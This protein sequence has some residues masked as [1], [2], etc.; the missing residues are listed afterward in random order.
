M[1]EKERNFYDKAKSAIYA[2]IFREPAA[3]AQT[4]YDRQ[5]RKK[6]VDSKSFRLYQEAAETGQ[7]F[8]CFSVGRC[9][10]EGRVV[11]KDLEKAYEWYQKGAT[12]G[13]VNA[14]VALGRMFDQGIYVDRDPKLSQMWL[15][16]AANKGHPLGMIGLG[17]Y[18]A[19]GEGGEKDQ[20]RALELFEQAHELNKGIA[21]YVLGEAI[22]DGIGCEKNYEKAFELF[23]EA[24]ANNYP[25][26]TFNVGMMLEMGLGC[27]KDEKKG[28]EF[29]QK[30]A[31]QGVSD[32]MYRLAFDYRD[33]SKFVEKD[34]KKS[35][36]LFLKAAEAGNIKACQEVGLMYENGGG[37]EKDE[38]KAFEYYEKAAK[39]GLH[40]AIVCLAV[41]YRSGIGCERDPQKARE[42]LEIGV[43]L[44]NTR[45]YHL[46]ALA[47]FEEDPND[48]RAV[49]LEMVAAKG[50]FN[51]S[52]MTLAY[53]FLQK[54]DVA[55]DKEKAKYYYR[56]AA[57]QGDSTAAFELAELLSSEENNQDQSVQKEIDALYH[58]SAENRHP[59]AAF[60]LAKQL[61]GT[62]DEEKY[63]KYMS[64]AASG[65]IAEAA[66]EMAERHFWGNKMAI[67]IPV[68]SA[69]F[70]FAADELCSDE[71]AAKGAITRI[72][73][74]NENKFWAIGNYRM[75]RLEKNLLSTK[76]TN[77]D[78]KHADESKECLQ[79]LEE[80]A[81]GGMELA[82]IF[83]PLAKILVLDSDL[84]AAAD[85]ALLEEVRALPDS[86]EKMFFQALTYACIDKDDI[87]GSVLRFKKLR[88]EM[89]VGNVNHFLG[90]LYRSY[91]FGTRKTRRNNMSILSLQHS[92]HTAAS[93]SSKT[94][95]K[96]R[97]EE[98]LGVAK[99]YYLEAYRNQEV[100]SPFMFYLASGEELKL[101]EKKAEIGLYIMAAAIWILLCMYYYTSGR[102]GQ[103][104]EERVRTYYYILFGIITI[105][106]GIRILLTIFSGVIRRSQRKKYMKELYHNYDKK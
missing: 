12:G 2:F 72:I 54:G 66:L 103:T 15:E 40:T 7:P 6:E 9:Y 74:R 41:C 101:I 13:D 16:R 32:A 17:K 29:I 35:F 83:L 87:A 75:D 57:N 61:E 44:G 47:L 38:K 36:E 3:Q 69:L 63:V 31:D 85:Q 45:A 37:C 46:L 8:A 71:Y 33:G 59:L 21:S 81:K 76:K 49:N 93:A 51:R 62:G 60:H 102:A 86:R 98:A 39:G 88:D 27:E 92:F 95:K 105:T 55:P 43:A 11:E 90:N 73:T 70:K 19:S 23:Q 30:A 26:A 5:W 106:L 82:K 18:Y 79:K 10:E 65:G 22:G 25:L 89:Q 78:P 99:E 67:N 50:G 20:K 80:L 34:Q 28:L 104:W 84:K 100:D 48:E 4:A 52:S 77:E 14:W 97:Q 1:E 96:T 56:Q 58:I 53:Y 42:L 24:D 91:A 94:E 64:I 68:S